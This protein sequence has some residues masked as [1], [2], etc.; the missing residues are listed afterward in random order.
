MKKTFET[1]V[2]KIIAL[3][4]ED[5]VTASVETYLENELP[6]AWFGADLES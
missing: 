4:C 5:I 1:P 6:I 2:V 3:N